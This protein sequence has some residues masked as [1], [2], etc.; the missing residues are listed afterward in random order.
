MRIRPRAK[1]RSGAAAVEAA[2]VLPVFLTVV[3]GMIDVSRLGMVAQLIAGAAR[4]G[5]RVAVLPGSAQADVQARV[6]SFLSGSGI[7]TV[8]PNVSP[9]TWTSAT[10]GTAITVSLSVPFNKVSW[11]GTPYLFGSTTLSASATFSSE[12][13]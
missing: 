5:C 13:P 10:G 7:P 12:N 9:S 2:V 3:F 8:T 1:R 4:E 6:T 11:M